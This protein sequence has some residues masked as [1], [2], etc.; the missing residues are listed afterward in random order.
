[1]TPKRTIKV[2][3]DQAMSQALE[4]FFLIY[5]KKFLYSDWLRV[6]QF[7]GNTVPKKETL[8]QKRIFS[9]NFFSLRF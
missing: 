7:L 1:M 3:K 5:M 6:V 8:C 2:I 9:A 4:R